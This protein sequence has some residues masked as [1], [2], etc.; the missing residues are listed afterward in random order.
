MRSL[1][2]RQSCQ[3]AKHK[4][5]WIFTNHTWHLQKSQDKRLHGWV[6]WHCK[7]NTSQLRVNN[8]DLF[9]MLASA[10]WFQRRKE[11][12][13]TPLK[14]TCLWQTDADWISGRLYQFSLNRGSS[15]VASSTINFI[16]C[17]RIFFYVLMIPSK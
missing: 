8:G 6:Q 12:G 13:G 11:K 1:R 17:V 2:W 7:A 3:K 10:H 14:R 9:A 15:Q 5:K 4:I 16:L